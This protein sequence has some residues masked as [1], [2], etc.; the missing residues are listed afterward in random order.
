[1]E[2]NIIETRECRHCKISFPI[3][4]KDKV[5]YDKISPSFA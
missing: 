2:E 4:D 3:T 1:M 5:F